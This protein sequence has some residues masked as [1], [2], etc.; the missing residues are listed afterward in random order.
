MRYH[1][2]FICLFL[3]YLVEEAKLMIYNLILFL[4]HKYGGKV[5]IYFTEE[6]KAETKGDKWDE[7]TNRVIC[8]I[9]TFLEEDL[10]DDIELLDA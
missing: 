6:V 4:H 10:E 1:R 7:A 3:P 5:L 8:S 2:E 9:D